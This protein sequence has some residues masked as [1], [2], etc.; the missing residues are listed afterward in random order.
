MALGPQPPATPLAE[1]PAWN[2]ALY[3]KR[4]LNDE[5]RER[6]DGF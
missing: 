5:I 6:N 1:R 4:N 2:L 3:G